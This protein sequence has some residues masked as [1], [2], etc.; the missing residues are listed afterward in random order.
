MI[1]QAMRRRTHPSIASRAALAV[2]LGVFVSFQSLVV[3]AQA[4]ALAQ[5]Y[6]PNGSHTLDHSDYDSLLK[7]FVVKSSDGVARVNYRGLKSQQSRLQAYLKRMQ[8]VNVPGLSSNAA[9]AFWM[10]LYNA[11]TLDVVL[12][13]LPVRSIRDI[14]LG[15]GL[16]ARGPWKKKILE[17]GDKALSLDD[18]EH[19]IARKTWKDPRLH[20][21]F[22][23]ASIGCPNLLTSAFTAKNVDRLLDEAAR[24][25]INHPRGVS[26]NKDGLTVSKLY[27]WYK[28]DFGN[29]RQ[30]FNHWSAYADSALKTKIQQIG[31]IK[32]YRY[33]W[34]LNEAR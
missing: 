11:K 32:A 17:V 14:N 29:E 16:L 6:I 25:Y 33:D 24:A 19:A 10:N 9:K 15:G 18:V 21:G 22:N 7:R 1:K 13:H 20:Y 12:D 23:C 26:A 27:Q 31:S 30:L 28:S 5:S 2:G 3:D 8:A 34:S 4:S